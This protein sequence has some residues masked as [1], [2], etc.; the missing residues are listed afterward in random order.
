M[1]VPGSHGKGVGW[2][3][4]SPR[5]VNGREQSSSK[6]GSDAGLLILSPGKFSSSSISHAVKRW[7][8]LELPA[9]VEAILQPVLGS[10]WSEH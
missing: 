5:G 1:D 7:C 10:C 6:F 9:A 3:E 8:D 2:E 4:T